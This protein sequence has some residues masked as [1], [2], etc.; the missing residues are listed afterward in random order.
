MFD[1]SWVGSRAREEL[2]QFCVYC[3]EWKGTC[4]YIHATHTQLWQPLSFFCQKNLPMVRQIDLKDYLGHEF[5]NFWPCKAIYVGWWGQKLKFRHVATCPYFFQFFLPSSDELSLGCN[6][7]A[8]K[9]ETQ[10]FF[11]NSI[12]NTS[13]PY[14]NLKKS[15]LKLEMQNFR[16]QLVSL[17]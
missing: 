6:P 1:G 11:G 2:P 15:P 5:R 3:Y 7:E 14:K 17:L 13:S 8:S 4:F 10:L 16:M 12:K 9:I